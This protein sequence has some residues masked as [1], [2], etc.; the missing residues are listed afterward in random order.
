M[1]RRLIA[2]ALAAATSIYPAARTASAAPASGATAPAGR[3]RVAV[4]ID[5]VASV[6][7]DRA[8]SLGEALADALQRELDVD[9]IGGGD[10]ERRLPAGGVPDDCLATP[11][12]IADLGSRLDANQLLFLSIAQVGGTARIDATWVDVA[13][14]LAVSRPRIDLDADTR[15]AEVFSAAAQRLLPDA[16]RRLEQTKGPRGPHHHMTGLTW[17]LGGVAVAALGGG[18]GIGLAARGTYDRCDRDP[19]SCDD[20]TRSGIRTHAV[21]ADALFATALAGAVTATVLYLR[22]NDRRDEA[23]AETWLVT[24]RRGGG[25]AEVRVRF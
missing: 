9:A 5:L 12:C 24:P 20:D 2:A 17:A 6:A 23:P 4:V 10:V 21:I 7:P 22:S 18:V 25:L 8:A 19:D 11:A 16:P 13:S 1:R 3:V 14:G 15:A